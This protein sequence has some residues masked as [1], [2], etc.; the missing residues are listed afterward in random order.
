MCL[1]STV[2]V[3]VCMDEML[4]HTCM[5][6]IRNVDCYDHVIRKIN[7]LFFLVQTPYSKYDQK[8]GYYVS[9]HV[10][11]QLS[12]KFKWYITTCK[13]KYTTCLTSP[14]VFTPS[15]A[16]RTTPCG[17]LWNLQLLQIYW[18]PSNASLLFKLI[19][20]NE[21]CSAFN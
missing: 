2:E 19:T 5:Q 8:P 12:I 4:R 21:L 17:K 6:T 11:W 10:V 3:T 18:K 15:L 9:M 20:W 14:L 1:F 13:I 7:N 16:S